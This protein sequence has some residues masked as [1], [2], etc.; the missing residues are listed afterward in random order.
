MLKSLSG[1]LVLVLIL[2]ISLCLGL[3]LV[4]AAC[5]GTSEGWQTLSVRTPEERTRAITSKIIGQKKGL[6]VNLDC[7]QCMI[8]LYYLGQQVDYGFYNHPRSNSTR[9]IKSWT[10]AR[11][12]FKLN[13]FSLWN[14]LA[15]P[16][17][18]PTIA[19]GLG[20]SLH[21]G[22]SLHTDMW[23]NSLCFKEIFCVPFFES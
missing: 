10:D 13:H 3:G 4:P 5:P 1:G 7:L 6:I 9:T 22:S 8:Q 11:G 15:L 23:A 20:N 12:L 18:R 21:R 17:L 19:S 16:F 2:E 14:H